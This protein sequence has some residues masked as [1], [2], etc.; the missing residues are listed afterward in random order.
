HKVAVVEMTGDTPI[1]VDAPGALILFQPKRDGEPD[2]QTAAERR[3]GD[4]RVE[5]A[6][7]KTGRFPADAAASRPIESVGPASQNPNAANA[8]G[9]NPSRSGHDQ[10]HLKIVLTSPKQMD[11]DITEQ[12]VGRI[13][14]RRHIN[15]R[16]SENGHLNEINVREG[17]AVKKGDLM[18]QI[19][20]NVN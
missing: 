17:Q 14:S 15:V 12:Y 19:A 2:C 3:H 1:R 20:P 5:V 4:T 9:A 6:D 11:V 8:S 16:A 10:E 7:E 18:F 13:H